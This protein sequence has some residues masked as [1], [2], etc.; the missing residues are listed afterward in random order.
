MRFRQA[1]IAAMFV[2]AMA[3]FVS[4]TAV[5]VAVVALLVDVAA[6][7]VVDRFVMLN[8][9]SSDVSD[10]LMSCTNPDFI[11]LPGSV[12]LLRLRLHGT[13][14]GFFLFG[15]FLGSVSLDWSHLPFV[16]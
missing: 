16:V 4:F 7:L 9:S 1:D 11:F 2:G 14:S 13:G 12:L 8:S 6:L 10:I 15:G 3:I 5:L